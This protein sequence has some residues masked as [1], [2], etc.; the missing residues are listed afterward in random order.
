MIHHSCGSTGIRITCPAVYPE[1]GFLVLV[2]LY[3][4]IPWQ[5]STTVNESPFRSWSA[6]HWGTSLSRS[7]RCLAPAVET[8]LIQTWISGVV[9]H[10]C[11]LQLPTNILKLWHD[12]LSS[13]L[14]VG[15][16]GRWEEVW[17]TVFLTNSRERQ[18]LT[19][20]MFCSFVATQ[21]ASHVSGLLYDRRRTDVVVHATSCG[22]PRFRLEDTRSRF[23][24][25]PCIVMMVM[26]C[27]VW[28]PTF[29][30]AHEGES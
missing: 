25:F 28:T 6:H 1:G 10:V 11:K 13:I 30:N 23:F 22:I 2:S 24:R 15:V 4:R 7:R 17:T 27:E 21:V 26:T 9:R 14:A 20:I 29:F 12:S 19:F 5:Y 16:D 18:K 8:S 3:M